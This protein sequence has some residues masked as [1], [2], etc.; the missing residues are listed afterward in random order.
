[1]T[2]CF[3]EFGGYQGNPG[4]ILGPWGDAGL[5]QV[6][7]LGGWRSRS[8]QRTAFCCS[9]GFDSGKGSYSWRIEELVQQSARACG[10][11]ARHRHV[12]KVLEGRRIGELLQH[13]R[14]RFDLRRVIEAQ[15]VV[16]A[17]RH[18]MRNR[19]LGLLGEQG[20]STDTK[21]ERPRG[22]QLF[23]ARDE[24]HRH[25]SGGSLVCWVVVLVVGEF[26]HWHRVIADRCARRAL[27]SKQVNSRPPCLGKDV[28]HTT[29]ATPAII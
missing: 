18:G 17:G 14:K 15:P 4:I 1:V 23:S 24:W 16:D 5:T 8:Y 2:A 13:G 3:R 22:R 10:E 26:R 11:I 7:G 6:R 28:C 19:A 29:D 27:E 12:A 20:G 9:S 25:D 21:R